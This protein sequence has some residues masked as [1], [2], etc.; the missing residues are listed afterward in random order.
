MH[1]VI[2][3]GIAMMGAVMAGPP[4]WALLDRGGTD[5]RHHELKEP[6]HLVATVREVPVIAGGDTK[7]PHHVQH[8][9]ED[10]VLPGHG[11]E[12]GGQWGGVDREEWNRR[13]PV[14]PI[15]VSY[16]HLTLP[17]IYSV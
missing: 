5:E 8:A 10:P 13:N 15:A 9:A 14:G 2:E 11:H 16:T 12:E 3:V 4:Q 6:S 17:T 1:I 7:H